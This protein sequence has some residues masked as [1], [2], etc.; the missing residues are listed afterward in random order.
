M[1][2]LAKIMNERTLQNRSEIKYLYFITV[3]KIPLLYIFNGL[4]P[5]FS[6]R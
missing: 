1:V 4:M 6:L 2:V 5:L 3:H